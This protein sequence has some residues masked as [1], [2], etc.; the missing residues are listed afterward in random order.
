MYKLLCSGTPISY[1][2]INEALHD[3]H[4][5]EKIE[6]IP[7]GKYQLLY[8]IGNQEFTLY[9]KPTGTCLGHISGIVPVEDIVKKYKIADEDVHV[10]F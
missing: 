4:D 1:Q 2:K 5:N 8:S 6:H 9:Y 10:S 7:I 3:L